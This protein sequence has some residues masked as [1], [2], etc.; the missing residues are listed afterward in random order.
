VLA[1]IWIVLI[2]ALLLAAPDSTYAEV[3]DAKTS[4]A[5]VDDDPCANVQVVATEST[6]DES[7]CPTVL[8]ENV[9]QP[10]ALAGV[11]RP[12]RRSFE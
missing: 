8:D 6:R 10:P 7:E 1:R 5:L 3:V 9:P 4:S 2:A 12:P 11:F